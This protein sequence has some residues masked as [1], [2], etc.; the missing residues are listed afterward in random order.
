MLQELYTREEL[1]FYSSKFG[2]HYVPER[3]PLPPAKDSIRYTNRI[4]DSARIKHLEERNKDTTKELEVSK[5]EAQK[6]LKIAEKLQKQLDKAKEET[7]R[8]KHRE[9]ELEANNEFLVNRSTEIHKLTYKAT[10]L[11]RRYINE[12][13]RRDNLVESVCDLN[14]NSRS[15]NV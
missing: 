9:T 13:N 6:A 12:N 8:L 10:S 1:F 4:N 5:E 15:T 14:A 7:Q 11:S 2:L 3:T